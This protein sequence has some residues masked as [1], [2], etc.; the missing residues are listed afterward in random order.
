MTEIEI[1]IT[2]M[3]FHFIAFFS[4]ISRKKLVVLNELVVLPG[5]KILTSSD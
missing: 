2:K 5:K 1:L 3:L 4:C